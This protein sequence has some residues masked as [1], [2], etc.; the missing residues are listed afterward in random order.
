MGHANLGNKNPNLK[1]CR[2]PFYDPISTWKVQLNKLW[3]CG[4]NPMVIRNNKNRVDNKL[5]LESF[6]SPAGVNL[7]FIY[8]AGFSCFFTIL[9][10]RVMFLIYL[11]RHLVGCLLSALKMPAT[12]LPLSTE[13]EWETSTFQGVWVEGRT[14]GGSRNFLSHWQNPSF[15]FTVCDESTVTSEVNVRITLQQ[16]RPET[17]LLPIGFHIYKVRKI[18]REGGVCHSELWAICLRVHSTH[19]L[20]I[21]CYFRN[22]FKCLR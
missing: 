12:P 21:Q 2:R 18:R 15:P 20:I 6:C 9:I 3:F 1:Y 14:A 5:K 4:F 17:D 7:N 22:V 13:G 19:S 8:K 10:R 11:W 16:N